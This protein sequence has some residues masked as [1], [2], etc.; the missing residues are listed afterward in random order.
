MSTSYSTEYLSDRYNSLPHVTKQTM[1]Q[2]TIGDKIIGLLDI[3]ERHSMGDNIGFHSLHRHTTLP[4]GTVHVESEA[5]KTGYKWSKA[6]PVENVVLSEVHPTFFKLHE[7][8]FVPFE[9]AE[10]PLPIVVNTIPETF[11]NKIAAYIADNGL[12][13]MLALQIGDFAARRVHEDLA[14]LATAE[15]E[16]QWGQDGENLTLCVSIN[17][18]VD[19]SG[20]V[21]TGWNVTVPGEKKEPFLPDGPPPGE[22]WLTSKKGNGAVTHK[23]WVGNTASIAPELLVKELIGMGYLHG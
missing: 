9:F 1:L 22:Y 12:V 18:L 4:N 3:A 8:H 21:Q 13:D 23:V 14:M 20:N 15:I 19:T 11:L 6:T 10:G 17:D 2:K 7:G 16:V 5:G